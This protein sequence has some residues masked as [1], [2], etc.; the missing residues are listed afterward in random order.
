MEKIIICMKWGERYSS[1]YVNRLYRSCRRNIIGPLRFICF[2]DN[3]ADILEEIEIR[4]LPEITLPK[5]VQWTGWQKISVWQYP[6]LDLKGD[7]LFL[8]IDLLV[9]GSLDAFFDFAPNEYCVIE[10][11]TQLGQSIGNTSVF[12][13]PAGR[14]KHVYDN[15]MKNTEKCLKQFRIEQQY[16]SAVIP[17]QKF[18]PA[19][20]CVSFKH[21]CLPKF[22]LNWIKCP[23]LPPEAR[24]VA[25]HGKPDPD[26]ALVGKWPAPWYK[27]FYKYVR[28]T[29]WIQEHWQ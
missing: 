18:W 22:P 25:F 3:G 28:P 6:L 15:L 12:K 29:P 21:T 27:K 16:I 1:D 2:T 13:F 10:N 26:E 11:W 7:V 8:D 24:I 20:W 19:N 5:N 23:L 4:P 17:S 14:F 9:T